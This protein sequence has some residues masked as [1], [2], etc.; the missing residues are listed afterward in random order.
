M[1]YNKGSWNSSY[2]LKNMSLNNW[3]SASKAFFFG[4]EVDPK[5]LPN[6]LCQ[7]PSNNPASLM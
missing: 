3:D 5:F 2:F 1:R 6:A 7:P 4:L